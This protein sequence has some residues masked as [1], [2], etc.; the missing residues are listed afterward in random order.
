MADKP[1]QGRSRY[2]VQPKRKTRATQGARAQGGAAKDSD[3]V[4][5]KRSCTTYQCK[6]LPKSDSDL[7]KEAIAIAR[8]RGF[9][10]EER[11]STSK[12]SK[13][14]KEP[15]KVSSTKLQSAARWMGTQLGRGIDPQAKKDFKNIGE[16][17]AYL[18]S[19]VQQ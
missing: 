19:I 16:A 4:K 8:R 17:R 14:T 1:K 12:V 5:S 2:K 3:S 10:G 11:L 9:K 18:Q 13:R 6:P 7:L 15:V